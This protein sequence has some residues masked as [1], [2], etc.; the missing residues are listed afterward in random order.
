MNTIRKYNLRW[1]CLLEYSK[2]ILFYILLYT[3]FQQ[4]F[5]YFSLTPS[6]HFNHLTLKLTNLKIVSAERY[7]LPQKHIPRIFTSS[8][9]KN[10]KKS[11]RTIMTK[12]PHRT[13][14]HTLASVCTLSVSQ[15]FVIRQFRFIGLVLSVVMTSLKCPPEDKLSRQRAREKFRF[16]AQRHARCFDIREGDS[17]RQN[18]TES[19]SYK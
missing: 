16:T 15:E 18:S 10:K 2:E 6:F 11:S 4:M 8:F 13:R 7:F 14:G 9:Y 1:V 12:V 19:L 17:R 3:S 5:F